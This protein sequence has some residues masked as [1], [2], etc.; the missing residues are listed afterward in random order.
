MKNV[1]IVAALVAAMLVVLVAWQNAESTEVRIVFATVTMSRALL[2]ALTFA[3]GTIAGL[4]LGLWL[5]RAHRDG[6]A[7]G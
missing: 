3:C 1:K 2:L 4:G 5:K 6:G 7:E